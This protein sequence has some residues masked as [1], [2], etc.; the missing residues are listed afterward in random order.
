MVAHNELYLQRGGGTQLQLT[1]F[2]Q[3]SEILNKL[4]LFLLLILFSI[5][6]KKSQF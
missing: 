6:K 2:Y 3:L 4:R 5:F 1:K